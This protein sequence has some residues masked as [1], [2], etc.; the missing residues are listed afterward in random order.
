MESQCLGVYHMQAIP[1]SMQ[2]MNTLLLAEYMVCVSRCT[3]VYYYVKRRKNKE[4]AILETMQ[5]DNIFFIFLPQQLDDDQKLFTS[6][7]KENMFGIY[8]NNQ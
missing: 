4:F 1:M 3:L 5:L 7:I 8:I 2:F 6:S